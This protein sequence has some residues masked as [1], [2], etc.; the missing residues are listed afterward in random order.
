MAMSQAQREAALKQLKQTDPNF[1]E[2]KFGQRM[3]LAF[4]RVQA[5]WSEQNLSPVRPFISDGVHERFSLQF[6]EQKGMG[7]RNPVEQVSV[8]SILLAQ[9]E[10][11]GDFDIATLRID[12]QAADYKVSLTDGKRIEGSTAVEPFA[13][14]WSFLRRR[15]AKT[16]DKNGLI[17][18]NCPNCGVAIEMNQSANCTHCGA[19]LRSGQYDWVLCEITQESEWGVRPQ[20]KV[21]GFELIRQNDP[22]LTLAAMEDRVSVMYWRR[23]EADRTGKADP[24]RKIADEAFCAQYAQKLAA[25]K[26]P[27]GRRDYY[28]QCAVGGVQTLGLWSDDQH[29]QAVIE[30]AWSGRRFII[31]P[32]GQLQRT[33]QGGVSHTLFVLQRQ[34]GLKTSADQAISSAHCPN[35]GAPESIDVSNACSFCGTVLND[36]T[37]GWVL[38]EMVGRIGPRGR[39]LIEKIRECSV[40]D[41]IDGRR[42]APNHT[43]QAAWMIR[44]MLADGQADANERRLLKQSAHQ[45]GLSDEQL[46]HIIDAVKS[47]QLESAQPADVGEE[48]VWLNDMVRMSMADGKMDSNERQLLKSV[49]RQC[50]VGEFDFGQMVNRA[51]ADLYRRT[52]LL[53]DRRQEMEGDVLRN[54]VNADI[55]HDNRY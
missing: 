41:P 15:G 36:G 6:Q 4:E 18:G 7:Y 12:A 3:T 37:R 21:P 52:R 55:Y 46:Q 27:D 49:A 19:I 14:Y 39:E 2:E 51:R 25:S 44:M 54:S 10:S 28:G 38:V 43:A 40:A 48:R 20:D 35:C 5:A 34:K 13:E 45:W 32:D 30:V 8:N 23:A 47:G 24:L 1:D 42:I 29:E 53:A 9:L 31:Q 17:E 50:G 11:D 22:E 33:E 16:L 26:R